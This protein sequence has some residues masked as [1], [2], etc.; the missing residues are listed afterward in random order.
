MKTILH[1]LSKKAIALV[2]GLLAY[3]GAN[4][5]CATSTIITGQTA[6]TVNIMNQSAF[7]ALYSS[8]ISIDFGDG[9]YYTG[10]GTSFTTSHT[11]TANG[12][13]II[14]TYLMAYDPA[15]S[16][17]YC[18]AYDL[19]TVVISGL[20]QNCNLQAY[21]SA[22]DMGNNSAYIYGYS[23]A[24]YT[25]SYI[26]VDGQIF[27]N[28]DSMSYTFA[29]PGTYQ[30]CYY[31]EDS[32]SA[33]YCYDS[34]CTTVTVTNGGSTPACTASFYIW[35]D[36]LNQ[37]MWF[38]INNSTTANPA[39]TTYFWDFGD[40]TSSTLAYPSHVYATP[41]N[42]VICLTVYDAVDSCS[43]TYCD[44]SAAMRLSSTAT[45][46]MGSITI[47]A[48]TG[49]TDNTNTSVETNLYP[50]PMTDNATV[51]F[52]SANA[53]KGSIQVVSVLGAI[54][55]SENINISKGNN[56][57]DIKTS[58]L[59]GGMYYVNVISGNTVIGTVKAVK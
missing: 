45:A 55:Y 57:I 47:S 2:L 14:N 10:S 9:G 46:T 19:D 44:S 12:T 1:E 21:V 39:A 49:I 16:N 23:N 38:G 50:N 43:A 27:W 53:S 13:Y 48:P 37:T 33:T 41:G 28:T 54:V 11:Y 4:A 35:P 59:A 17:N 32:T 51:K 30:V 18:N 40:G 22:S 24:S 29:N 7:N 25:S 34:T 56:N 15:D 6:G 5:Q 31:I 26:S 3:T 20:T 52:E 42:Y 58:S 36:S 8:Y